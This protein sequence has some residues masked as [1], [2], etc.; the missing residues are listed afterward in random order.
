MP[1]GKERPSLRPMLKRST[2]MPLTKAV[3]WCVERGYRKIRIY[4]YD[5]EDTDRVRVGVRLDSL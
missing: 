3:T 1:K 4:K 2:T 5:E